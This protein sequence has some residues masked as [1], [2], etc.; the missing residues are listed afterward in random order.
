MANTNAPRTSD[1]SVIGTGFGDRALTDMSRA[2][3]KE[4]DK[5]EALPAR[6]ISRH[7]NY[8]TPRGLK[9]IESEVEH[10]SRLLAVAH[11]E[12]DMTMVAAVS[13]DL[14]YWQQRRASAQ[15]IQTSSD[16]SSVH[17][18]AT[19]TVERDDGTLLRWR[20]VGEDE[21]DPAS[22]AIAYISPVARALMNRMVGDRVEVGSTIGTIVKIES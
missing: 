5:P 22:G 4:T 3:I 14:R 9:L 10:L 16:F 8:V 15:V 6:V 17:F 11:G 21:A 20:I 7:P 12:G 18:G 2:F 13:R 19:V 1:E